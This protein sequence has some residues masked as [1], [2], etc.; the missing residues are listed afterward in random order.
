[1]RTRRLASVTLTCVAPLAAALLAAAAPVCAQSSYSA[2]LP[3][4]RRLY[5]DR[6][7]G[8]AA[9]TLSLASAYGRQEMGRSRDENVALRLMDTESRLDKLV[10]RLR[11]KDD[12]ALATLDST[13]AQTDRLL[14]EHH[15]RL[16]SWGLTVPKEIARR[17][18]GD[19]IGAA[20]K[21]FAQSFR[22]TGREPDASTALVIDE[23]RRVADTIL[24]TDVLPKATR[25]V[26]EALGR[27]IVPPAVVATLP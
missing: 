1:M 4:V 24:A 10:A 7:A 25:K 2:D 26:M 11:A 27:R 18:V 17:T 6:D 20:A 9:H 15:W 8:R 3:A 16:A 21:F 14:A 12:V 19:D 22:F 5:V 23:A 13:F